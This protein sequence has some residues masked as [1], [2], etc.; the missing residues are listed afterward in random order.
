[1]SDKRDK[2]KFNINNT[3]GAAIIALLNLPLNSHGRVDTVL[4]DKSEYGL[5]KTVE[6]II[7][8]DKFAKSLVKGA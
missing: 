7:T 4:G 8:D 1:M 2:A 6:R 3:T 5:A